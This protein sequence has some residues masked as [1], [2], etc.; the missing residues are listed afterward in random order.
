M[1]ELLFYIN[2]IMLSYLHKQ[3]TLFYVI[4]HSKLLPK[5]LMCSKYMLGFVIIF[6]CMLGWKW[7]LTTCYGRDGTSWI[8]NKTSLGLFPA[9]NFQ[10]GALGTGEPLFN[11]NSGRFHASLDRV[12]A[13]LTLVET[14]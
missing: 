6:K 9:M 14:I 10:F 11:M 1:S 12:E 3:F 2:D 7:K 4:Y 5:L 13:I 8:Q